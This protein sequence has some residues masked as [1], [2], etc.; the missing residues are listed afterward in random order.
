MYTHDIIVIG[1]GA[2][3]LTVASGCGQLGMKTAVIEREHM[4]GDCL[5]FGCVPSKT[6]LHVASQFR[7]VHDVSRF[8]DRAVPA[9]EPDMAAV[10]RHIAGVVSKIAHHD[11][12]ERFRSLGVEV[13]LGQAQFRS[14]NEVEV[15]SIRLSARNIV[16]ATGSRAAIPPI[17]GLAESGYLTNRDMFSMENL[18]KSLAIMGGGPIGV[19]LGQ[20]YRR[21]GS[22]VSIIEMAPRILPRD[23][24]DAAAIVAERIER[25][26]IHLLTGSKVTKVESRGG[27]K[28][29]HVETSDGETVLEAEQLLV[30]AGR[31]ANVDTLNLEAAGVA[32]ER[33]AIAVNDKL[34]SSVP[35]IY[36]IGDANGKFPFTHVAG[37][38]ASAVVRRVALHAGG[39]VDYTKVPWVSYTDPELANVG[40]SEASALEAGITHRVVTQSFAAVDRAHAEES[41]DGLLKI[42]LDAKDRVIGTQIASKAAGELIGPALHA[43]NGK[44]KLGQFR[45]ALTPYPTMGEVYGRAVSNE[46]A[47]KLFNRRT[48]SILRALFRYRGTGPVQQ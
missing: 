30:A 33:G 37:M 13:F 4:G 19:E 8:V 48:R 24:E 45:K 21:L 39:R 16:V 34:Q 14:S 44:W 40:Y 29:L 28:V 2:A 7:S 17:P 32:T 10:N 47:P 22:K 15:D 31:K 36:A 46:L 23:D 43:V 38:E 3:G 26:G 41:A 9:P 25:E 42:V 5:H 35:H 6:I 18:P 11:S 1:G 12:P 20:A 27:V